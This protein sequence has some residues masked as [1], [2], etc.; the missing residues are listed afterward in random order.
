LDTKIT[1]SRKLRLSRA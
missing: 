1:G